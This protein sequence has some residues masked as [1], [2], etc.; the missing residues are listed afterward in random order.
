[1]DCLITGE[2]RENTEEIL[3]QISKTGIF[4]YKILST[5]KR[6]VHRIDIPPDWTILESEDP[7]PLCD[8][9]K[10]AKNILRSATLSYNGIEHVTNAYVFRGRTD[11]NITSHGYKRLERYVSSEQLRSKLLFDTVGTTTEFFHFSDFCLAGETIIIKRAFD[12]LYRR[13][14]DSQLRA[15]L[16][17]LVK[18]SSSQLFHQK[19]YDNI[20]PAET[21]NFIFSFYPCEFKNCKT[22]SQIEANLSATTKKIEFFDLQD[23]FRGPRLD[24]RTGIKP[25][26]RYLRGKISVGSTVGNLI[27]KLY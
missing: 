24:P 4:N 12:R 5:W 6:S 7:G 26:Y 14:H 18:S 22:L 3:K 16:H 13:L 23:F 17:R 15:H 19:K 2:I 21:M 20:C 25:L 10:K 8:V 1:M 11:I 27:D 9:E